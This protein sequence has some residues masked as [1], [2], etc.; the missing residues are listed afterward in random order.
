MK[1][2]IALPVAIV[3]ATLFATAP[4][5]AGIYTTIDT[6][7]MP[8][9]RNIEKFVADT[10]APVR[11]IGMDGLK[12]DV[13]LFFDPLQNPSM[14]LEAAGGRKPPQTLTLEEKLN[15]SAVLIRRKKYQEAIDFLL[16]LTRQHPDIFLFQA[17]LAMAYWLSG[18]PG[19]DQR[20]IDVQST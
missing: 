12:P 14:L 5:R 19:Y 9:S 17:H 6:G 1:H 8:L 11:G 2:A 16:P 15:Y 10:L 20:A 7:D 18:Q 13:P 4:A 3:V